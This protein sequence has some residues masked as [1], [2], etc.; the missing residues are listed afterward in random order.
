MKKLSVVICLLLLCVALFNSRA[1]AF[2]YHIDSFEVSNTVASTTTTTT[3][4]FSDTF[5]PPH[6]PNGAGAG[7]YFVN[8]NISSARESG[9]LLELN[10]DDAVPSPWND[11]EVWVTLLD[12]SILPTSGNT[13]YVEGQFRVNN[14]FSNNTFFGIDIFNWGE[15]KPETDEGAWMDTFTSSSGDI[16]ARWGV[17]DDTF[18]DF[19]NITSLVG[20]NTEINMKLEID[21]SKMVSAFWTFEGGVVTDDASYSASTFMELAYNTGEFYLAGFGAAEGLPVPEPATVALLGIGLVGLAGAEVRR[22]RK[23]RAVDKS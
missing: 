11:V 22:R 17:Y 12:G 14:G 18:E 5:E 1:Y 13:G 6:G 16:Y 21:S 10:S 19:F 15:E 23:K 8:G 4:A 2:I 20:A 9:G 3:D 7:T